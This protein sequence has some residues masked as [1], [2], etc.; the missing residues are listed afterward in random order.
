MKNSN[1]ARLEFE[2]LEDR[3]TPGGAFSGAITAGT[4]VLPSLV[5]GVIGNPS[6]V[7][8]FGPGF[9]N[10]FAGTSQ[11]TIASNQT[12]TLQSELQT[13]QAAQ[14]AIID[15]YFA[16]LSALVKALNLSTLLII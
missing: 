15:Q 10:T 13:L 16:N 12:Q 8:S 4:P 7:T 1:A 3:V 14:T 9:R 5:T 6:N 2:V 11:D